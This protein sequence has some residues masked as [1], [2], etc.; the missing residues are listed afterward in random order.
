[1][2]MTAARGAPG[3]GGP[4]YAAMVQTETLAG[5]VSHKMAAP[6]MARMAVP[7][8]EVSTANMLACICLTYYSLLASKPL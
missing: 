5:Q 7:R 4:V 8:A 2:P 3:G 1:M 6:P